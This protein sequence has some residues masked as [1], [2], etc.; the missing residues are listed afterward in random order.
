MVASFTR[1]KVTFMLLVVCMSLVVG[2][3]TWAAAVAVDFEKAKLMSKFAK[4]ISWPSDAVESDFIIGVYQDAEKHKF[5]SGYFAGKGVKGKDIDV[6]LVQTMNE[7][8]RVNILYVPSSKRNFL[9]SAQQ[10]MNGL[11]VLIVTENSKK[12]DKTMIDLSYNKQDSKIV[13]RIN[14]ANVA[15]TKLAVPELSSF[16][17]KDD[18]EAILS[19][20][21]TEELKNKK[22]DEI[23]TLKNRLTVQEASMAKLSQ[24]LNLSQQSATTFN[25]NLQKEVKRLKASQQENIK[26]NAEIQLKD[27]KLKEL[28]SQLQ[29]Q[30]TQLDT[31]LEQHQVEQTQQQLD[32]KDSKIIDEQRTKERE[33]TAANLS[34]LTEKLK[35]QQ[36]IA[37]KSLLKLT[38]MTN[39]NK[40]LSN[41]K[42]LFYVFALIAVAAVVAAFMMWKK[43]K[44]AEISPTAI[45]EREDDPLLPVRELQLTK[46]ENFAALGYIATDVTYAVALSLDDFQAKL[47]S[48][49]DDKNLMALKPMVALLENFNLIAADQ[50]DTDV[51]NFDVVAYMQKMMMLYDF[52][53]G[54]SDIVYNYSGDHTLKIKSIPSYVALVLLNVINNSLKHGFDN[55]GSGKVALKVEKGVNGGVEISYSDNGKGMSKAILRQVFKPFFTTQS[56]RGYVGVGMST[57]YDI[58]KNKLSG[59]ITIDSKEGEGTTVVITLP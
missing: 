39:E 36:N 6:R 59:D 15:K 25:A 20:G 33:K 48:A 28:T 17:E 38:N 45:P 42:M 37:S 1:F 51:Q 4:Y 5:F 3:Q 30:K 40:S 55:N 21:P 35:T 41:F 32:T 22:T 16:L 27:K 34:E 26:K 29:A 43:S 52:E 18:N 19:V 31:Q 13:L 2:G 50:D 10:T 14:N 44:T 23:S 47:E 8:K 58:V 24:K 53:F 9:K 11:D 12:L 7:A 54:Q 46:S 49:G 57:T 56:E